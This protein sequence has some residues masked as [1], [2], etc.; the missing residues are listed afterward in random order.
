[1]LISPAKLFTSSLVPF[2][3]LTVWSV[4]VSTIIENTI[5]A[6][7]FVLC[8]CPGSQPLAVPTSPWPQAPAG[9]LVHLRQRRRPAQEVQFSPPRF[10]Q[11]AAQIRVRR[12][13]GERFA[14]LRDRLIDRL[15]VL[16]DDRNRRLIELAS[17]LLQRPLEIRHRRVLLVVREADADDCNAIRAGNGARL[18]RT[19]AVA[20]SAIRRA[21]EGP[22]YIGRRRLRAQPLTA[23]RRRELPGQAAGHGCDQYG[24]R[25]KLRDREAN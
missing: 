4:G 8:P 23:E 19:A 21:R 17:P 1:M 2:A 6:S 10:H 25:G 14:G 13:G 20:R 18:R 15:Q 24:G 11:V 16:F 7:M 22:R 3:T 12:I 9:R 5:S